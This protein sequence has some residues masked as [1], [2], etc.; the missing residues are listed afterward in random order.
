MPTNKITLRQVNP[1][2]ERSTVLRLL[3]E[4]LP[5]EYGF[6]NYEYR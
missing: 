2:I 6:K 1:G 4:N 3:K 5:K